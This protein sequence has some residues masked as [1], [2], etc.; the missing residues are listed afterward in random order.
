MRCNFFREKFQVLD[1]G[2][3]LDY[4]ALVGF[5]GWNLTEFGGI[6]RNLMERAAFEMTNG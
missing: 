1:F 5:E 4:Q 3:G 2:S 6:S